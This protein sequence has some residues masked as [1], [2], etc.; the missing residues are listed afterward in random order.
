[1]AIVE[2]SLARQLDFGDSAA[3]VTSTGGR[4][5]VGLRL[6]PE[7]GRLTGPDKDRLLEHRRRQAQIDARH[8]LHLMDADTEKAR[9]EEA[10]REEGRRK[11]GKREEGKRARR[12][13]G[14]Q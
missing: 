3:R 13:G 11:E 4:G 14:V 9:R 8:L 7:L 6:A 10:R 2:G 12:T 1:M 5:R